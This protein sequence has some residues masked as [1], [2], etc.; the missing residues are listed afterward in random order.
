MTNWIELSKRKN[1]SDTEKIIEIL[2]DSIKTFFDF[3]S[4]IRSQRT[5]LIK[6]ELSKLGLKLGYKVW[7]N[8][9]FPEDINE[10]MNGTKFN[11]EEFDENFAKEE[12]LY[13][14]HWYTESGHYTPKSL[15]LIMECEWENKRPGDENKKDY[16]TSVR[17]DFQKLVVS[18]A[19]LRLMIFIANEKGRNE[20]GKYFERV[21]KSYI[22]L[23]KDAKFLFIAYDN[24]MKKCF[25]K[26]LT[27]K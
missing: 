1:I 13:D 22:Q 19:T 5:R 12:W 10:I 14:L 11:E 18:N 24:R 25:Y 27:K 6:K 8:R 7:T 3:K 2:A 4:E 9:L 21:I 23:E 26:E 17:F 15:P 16:G 20:L